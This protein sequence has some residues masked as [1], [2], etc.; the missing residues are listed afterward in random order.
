[1]LQEIGGHE[2]LS[3]AEEAVLA[4]AIADGRQAEAARAGSLTGD[5]AAGNAAIIE[6]G[7]QA[8]Q[9]FIQANLRLVVSVAK[10]YQA[11]GLPLIDLVQEGNLGL[12]RAVEKFDHRKGFKFSTY[13]TW[14]IR[15]AVS[16]AIADK[17]RTIRVPVHMV[18]ILGQVQRSAGDLARALGREP[19]VE[20]I[21]A[22]TGLDADK[23]VEA[24][25]VAPDPVSLF[26]EVGDEDAELVEF[27]A[28]GTAESPLDAA[29][30]A[31]E[32]AELRSVLLKLSERERRVVALR[33][34]L[35]GRR[36]WT[37]DE[38]GREL[39][40]TRERI[41]Q[42]EAKA[43]SKLRHPSTRTAA[44]ASGLSG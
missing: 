14:W 36:P 39:R 29:V 38:V 20:E 44:A 26:A 13:A 7:R 1:Y 25:R 30:T 4:Q 19:T 10:R 24:R 21:A 31:F 42:I 5:V 32:L 40:V 12:M 27:L 37:L 3:A 18:E 11:S 6:A 16:R 8:R 43:L 22:D 17:A 34:G 41:R 23:V 9:R 2:L 28:D 33:F 15:Q 35:D